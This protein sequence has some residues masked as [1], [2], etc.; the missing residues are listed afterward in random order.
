MNRYVNKRIKLKKKSAIK[1]M[2]AGFKFAFKMM[3]EASHGPL[4]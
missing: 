2:L 1:L 4:L 3:E